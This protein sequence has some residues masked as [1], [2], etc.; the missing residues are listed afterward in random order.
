MITGQPCKNCGTIVAWIKYPDM[1]NPLF[2][3]ST[4]GPSGAQYVITHYAQRCLELSG[5]AD[6]DAG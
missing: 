2:E 6:E 5:R 1:P 4:P 3:I